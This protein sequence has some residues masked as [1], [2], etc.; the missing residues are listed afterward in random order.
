LEIIKIDS[1]IRE[2]LLIEEIIYYK[3]LCK[4]EIHIVKYSAES[5]EV[6]RKTSK[7]IK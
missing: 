5:I 6:K 7:K 3:S 2:I 1:L 4:I